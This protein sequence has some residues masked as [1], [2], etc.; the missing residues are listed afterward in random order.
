[1][2]TSWASLEE[3]GNAAFQGADALVS[4]VT[5]NSCKVLLGALSPSPSCLLSTGVCRTGPYH[6]IGAQLRLNKLEGGGGCR[7]SIR[8]CL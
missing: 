2:G 4:L 1:M 7:E 8:R 5:I 3:R 6:H